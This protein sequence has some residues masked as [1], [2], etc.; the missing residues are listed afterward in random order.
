M[1]IKNKIVIEDC[2]QCTSCNWD[3]FK[4]LICALTDRI[5]EKE[6]D[7]CPIPNWCPKLKKKVK[8]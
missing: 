1:S 7:N 4:G 6:N 3:A 8:K 5:I 2:T